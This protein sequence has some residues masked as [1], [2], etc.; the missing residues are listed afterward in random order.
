MAR[1]AQKPKLT[2]KQYAI[3]VLQVARITYKAAPLSIIL[4]VIGSIITALLPIVTTYYAALTTTALAAAYAGNASAGGEAIQYVLIT[5]ALSVGM[6]AWNS[7]DSYIQN[8]MRYKVD[9]AISDKMYE[10]FLS[11]E[12]WRYDDKTTIDLYDRATDFARFFPYIFDKLATVVTQLITMLAGLVA[13]MMVSWW[14]G[15]I[16]IAAVIPGMMLQFKLSKAQI[17]HRNANFDTRR[18]QSMIEW[19]LLQ[20]KNI[21]E[22][23]LYGLVRYLLNMRQKL[24]DKDEKARILFERKFIFKQLGSDIIEAAAEVAALLWVV[25]QIIAHAQPIGQFLYVQQVVSRALGGARSFASTLN[26]IDQDLAN[27]FDYQKFMQLPARDTHQRISLKTPPE[28]IELRDISFHYPQSN[29]RVLDGVSLRIEKGQHVAIVGE[30]GAGKSTLIKMLTGL[31]EPVE[32]TVLIDGNDMKDIRISSWHKHLSVLQQNYLEYQFATAKENIVYGDVESPYD[33]RNF[34]ASMDRAEARKFLEKLPKGTDSYVNNWMEHDDGVKGAD[35]S[36]GQW[37]RL[38]L[39][40]NFYRN[41]PVIIL[42]EPTSAIDA[43][44]EERI[45]DHLFADRKHTVV[46]ISH[47][48][49]TIEKA[50]V[51]YMLQ[52]GKIVEQGTHAKLVK[53]RGAYYSMFKSQLKE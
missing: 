22:L 43:L 46:T 27:L 20:P 15:L 9:A 49:S 31:Y 3:A 42:D 50:D 25:F 10:H 40:R 51:I 41:S 33:Q 6:L 44:A 21:A 36:G 29:A 30:N 37:Q 23:R 4:K 11:L 28:I 12:F 8:L 26:T 24:R 38:A 34:D 32:G 35:L 45:F 5:A 13:L 14:L 19:N 47:R 39:A 17:D 53:A 1:T 7:V 48:L 2:Y 52:N 18:T 16:L